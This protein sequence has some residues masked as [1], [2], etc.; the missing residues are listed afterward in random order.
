MI[1]NFVICDV[2]ILNKSGNRFIK[3]NGRLDVEKISLPI[4]YIEEKNA[5]WETNGLW[6]EI[7]EK[8]TDEYYVYG[9]KK[10]KQR[11]QANEAANK[12]KDIL[13]DVIAKGNEK[14]TVKK[15]VEVIKEDDSEL[16]SLREQYLEKTG[17]KAHHLWKADKLIEKLK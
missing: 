11:E 15:E 14:V 17:K 10:R 6:H 16:D 2:Y 7:D 9:E 12:L 13:T 8:A 3:E 4:A 1:R 5:N